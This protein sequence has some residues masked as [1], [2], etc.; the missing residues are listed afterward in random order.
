MKKPIILLIL[1]LLPCLLSGCAQQKDAVVKQNA[2][3]IAPQELLGM[4]KNTVAVEER[5]LESVKKMHIGR[6]KYI[7]D[8]A[9][10]KYAKYGK[11]VMLWVTTY[12][13]SSI[14]QNET[15]RMVQAMFD[16]KDWGSKLQNFKVEDKQV[17]SL[18]REDQMHYF[19]RSNYC[20]F[21]FVSENIND[22]ESRTI[23][24][25]LNC[26]KKWI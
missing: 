8:V 19:W 7:E 11:S 3:E 22:T 2:T 23:I 6:I 1:I 24:K 20:M 5:A 13:N 10:F 21:Y 15:D 4:E 12:S 9:I 18:P 17:Y 16:F 14:A 25:S 26:D